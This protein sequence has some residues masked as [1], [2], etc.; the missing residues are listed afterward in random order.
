MALTEPP[1]V[2]HGVDRY[3]LA[4]ASPDQVGEAGVVLATALCLIVY[5]GEPC[6]SVGL[7]DGITPSLLHQGLG[8]DLPC[9]KGTWGNL[10]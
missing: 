2:A 6:A 4:Q 1:G 5:W 8:R 9:A 10:S 3:S 7:E